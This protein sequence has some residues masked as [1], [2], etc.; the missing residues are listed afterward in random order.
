AAAARGAHAMT[1][2]EPAR[3]PF[4]GLAGAPCPEF[5]EILLA[6]EGEFRPVAG[7]AVA[8]RL[9]DL[10]RPLFTV[11]GAAAG[12]RARALADAAQRAL[13]EDGDDPAC[14]LLAGTLDRGRATAAL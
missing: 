14:W 13:P 10:A 9:D 7:A 2:H 4:A 3:T 11:A 12:E 6:L 1:A 8:E 5:D